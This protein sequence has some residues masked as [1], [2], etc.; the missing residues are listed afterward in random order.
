MPI[1]ALC[2]KV[3]M[4][5]HKIYFEELE[6]KQYSSILNT[7]ISGIQNTGIMSMKL[8]PEIIANVSKTINIFLW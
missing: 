7:I 6:K 4:F 3:W 5:K 8:T 2:V 1:F